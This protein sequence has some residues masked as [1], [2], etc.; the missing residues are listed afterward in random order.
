MTKKTAYMGMLVTL[1][2][3]FSY[4]EMMLPISIGIPGVK[5]GLANIVIIV[6]LY[7]MGAGQAFMLSLVRIIL[8]G[9]TFGNLASMIYSLGGG[10]LSILVMIITRK[11]KLFSITGVSVLGAI[12]HNIG[13]I[14]V[15]VLVIENK[16]LFYYLPVI[17]VSGIAT[18][19]IIGVVG[20]VLVKRLSGFIGTHKPE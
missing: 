5:L 14:L 7:T 12:S 18:G 20:A 1:A 8:M 4:I 2:F 16:S 15:A 17:L 10:L 9:F 11:T 13:Q 6:A 3:I 19:I